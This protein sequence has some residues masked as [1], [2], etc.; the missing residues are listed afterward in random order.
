MSG[1]LDA[2]TR[3]RALGAGALDYLAKPFD[4]AEVLAAIGKV[5]G[6]G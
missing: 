5:F 3:E 6:R 4:A 1:C 2:G